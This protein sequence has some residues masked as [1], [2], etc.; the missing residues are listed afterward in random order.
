MDTPAALPASRRFVS[1]HDAC[2]AL[3]GIS[4][5]SLDRG[6][7]AGRI[8]YVRLGNRVLIPA[9]FFDDLAAQAVA[10]KADA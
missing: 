8:P 1:K 6:L 5:A 7:R 9:S 2:E 3:G 10:N 4:L